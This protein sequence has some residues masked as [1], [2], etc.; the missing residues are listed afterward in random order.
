LRSGESIDQAIDAVKGLPVNGYLAN[1]CAPES[2]TKVIPRLKKSGARWIGGYAN[3][4]APIP[5]DWI[6]DGEKETDGLLTL[7][8]DLDP[9]SYCAHAADWLAAGAS[10]VGGCCGTRPA[11]I[12]KI[13][14]LID[15]G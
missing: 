7:R 2:I 11:H 10:V 1:C 12:A 14:T 6:L 3:T 5:P 4:F 13:R 9:D 8:S 15:A